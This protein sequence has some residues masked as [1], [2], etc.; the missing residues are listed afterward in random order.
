MVLG[1]GPVWLHSAKSIS[2]EVTERKTS[3]PV[4]QPQ[5]RGASA[6]KPAVAPA[7]ICPWPGALRGAGAGGP[8]PGPC[9][10][11]QQLSGAEAESLL[12]SC[13]LGFPFGNLPCHIPTLQQLQPAAHRGVSCHQLGTGNGQLKPGACWIVF[14]R[15]SVATPCQEPRPPSSAL[16]INL[17]FGDTAGP[18]TPLCLHTGVL[19][20]TESLRA[21][22]TAAL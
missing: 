12:C 10:E 18:A 7:P 1:V 21:T 22:A 13:V 2:L 9:W 4:A 16:S 3:F 19:R 17:C 20:N 15:G 6:N 11:P 5:E 14:A 8:T